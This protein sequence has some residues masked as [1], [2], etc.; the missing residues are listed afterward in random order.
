MI[1]HCEEC[2]SQLND[3]G[4]HYQLTFCVRKEIKDL[5]AKV[6]TLEEMSVENIKRQADKVSKLLDA[7][8]IKT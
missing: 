6:S 3:E 4:E 5:K 8:P 2:H 7:N 1:K